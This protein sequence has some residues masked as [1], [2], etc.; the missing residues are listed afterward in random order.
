[1]HPKKKMFS[2]VIYATLQKHRKSTKEEISHIREGDSVGGERPPL[3]VA[4]LISVALRKRTE[5]S[6]RLYHSN[7]TCRETG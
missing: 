2:V 6:V 1:M 7:W 4:A 3:S 5:V